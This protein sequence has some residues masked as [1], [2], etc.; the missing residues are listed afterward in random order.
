MKFSAVAKFNVVVFILFTLFLIFVIKSERNDTQNGPGMP[1]AD[2]NVNNIIKGGNKQEILDSFQKNLV[3]MGYRVVWR[4]V[5]VMT[6]IICVL[7]FIV[8]IFYKQYYAHLKSHF[9]FLI[10]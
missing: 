7:L 5:F 3:D 2:C 6:Y 9:Y 4:K 8:L 1:F 10:Y